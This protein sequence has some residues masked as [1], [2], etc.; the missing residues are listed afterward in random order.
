[1]R[2]AACP[3]AFFGGWLCQQRT[4]QSL[5]AK[6]AHRA[7]RIALHPAF[8]DEADLRNN[9]T[10]QS[11]PKSALIALE[12]SQQYRNLEHRE[13]EIRSTFVA[14]NCV[15]QLLDL[16]RRKLLERCPEADVSFP[17]HRCQKIPFDQREDQRVKTAAAVKSAPTVVV[18]SCLHGHLLILKPLPEDRFLFHRPTARDERKVRS[19]DHPPAGTAHPFRR[20]LR[21][22]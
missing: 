1:M 4:H 6:T 7:P 5:L 13:L 2:K 18:Q 10:C 15:V 17:Q 9:A 11:H 16:H 3:A 12:R 22:R 21:T 8:H 20:G 19:S 14:S